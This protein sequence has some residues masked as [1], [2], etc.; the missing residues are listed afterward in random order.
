MALVPYTITA[1]ERDVADA[2]ITGKQVVVGAVCS[3]FLQPADTAVLMYDNADGDNGNT[4]KVTNS[5]GQVTVWVDAG[6]YRVSV[7]GND[8]FI[9]LQSGGVVPSDTVTETQTLIALQTTVTLASITTTR[10][11]FYINGASVDNGRLVLDVDYTLTSTSEIELATDYPAGTLITAV[12]NDGTEALF[13]AIQVYDTIADMQLATPPL[14][15]TL[16]TKGGVTVNDGLG[17]EYLV[18]TSGTGAA[19]GNEFINL[20]ANQAQKLDSAS[21]AK[22]IAL[23]NSKEQELIAGTSSHNRGCAITKTP[24]G[25]AVYRS[26]GADKWVEYLLSNS[27]EAAVG[28]DTPFK[29]TSQRLYKTQGF[30]SARDAT[31]VGSWLELTTLDPNTYTGYTAQQSAVNNDTLTFSVQSQ[32][33]L[34]LVYTG[35]TSGGIASVTVDGGTP[36]LVDTYSATDL[37]HK[38]SALLA[39][40]LDRSTRSIVVS[41]TNTKNASSTGFTVLAEGIRVVDKNLELDSPLNKPQLWQPNQ[42]Y[43]VREEVRSSTGNYYVNAAAGTSGTTEPSHSSGAVSDGGITWNYVGKSTYN[44][45]ETRVQA[46]GSELEYAFEFK[47]LI[48]DAFQDVGGN[49]HG[50]EFVTSLMVL[51]DGEAQTMGDNTLYKGSKI[52]IVQDITQ[53]LDAYAT[54]TDFANVQQI[55]AFSNACM[56]VKLLG[57]LLIDGFVG[58][59]YSAMFPFLPYFGGLNATKTFRYFE[60]PRFRVDL[61]DYQNAANT[62]IGRQEDFCMTAEGVAFQEKTNTGVPS[63][64]TSPT[65]IIIGCFVTPRSVDDYKNG[66]NTR[67]GLAVNLNSG[68]YTGFSSWVAKMYFTRFNSNEASPVTAGQFFNHNA[69]YYCHL[70][71]NNV[72]FS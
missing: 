50:N 45:P 7:N 16:K 18:V 13:S 68:E 51:I 59:Y 31:S 34:F 27:G 4:A 72:E 33:D 46:A 66:S 48:G 1:I 23:T 56:E 10:T 17:A 21:L 41:V 61:E 57:D 49:L 28:V 65:N 42:A 30:V 32:G 40:N 55:H 62:I 11:A 67:A 35:R 24:T 52:D 26:A 5:S 25:Y 47:R 36:V 53:H 37:K 38:S 8:S 29:V 12:Q 6:D 69:R 43:A 3:M 14:G 71:Q 22:S 2:A 58:Y 15:Y 9:S 39:R 44:L 60:S 63:V 64:N 20:A 54:R 70:Q 19:D